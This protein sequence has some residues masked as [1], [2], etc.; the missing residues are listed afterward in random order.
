MGAGTGKKIGKISRELT[1]LSLDLAKV[2]LEVCCLVSSLLKLSHFGWRH[3]HTF[4]KGGRLLAT[5][6]LSLGI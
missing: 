2:S 3:L 1:S 5:V 6:S 4:N